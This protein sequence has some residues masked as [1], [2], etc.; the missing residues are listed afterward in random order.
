M[1]AGVLTVHAD[2]AATVDG[3]AV[4]RFA[5]A[6][7]RDADLD[8]AVVVAGAA[9]PRDARER[10]EETGVTVVAPDALVDELDGHEVSAPRAGADR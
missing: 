2:A 10:A 6:V 8:A 4:E 3:A 7:E 5:A 1:R 9:L